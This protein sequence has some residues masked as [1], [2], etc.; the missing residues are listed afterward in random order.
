MISD[1]LKIY[2]FFLIIRLKIFFLFVWKKNN[3]QMISDTLKIYNFFFFFNKISFE[4]F[5][6]RLKKN[7]A[8]YFWYPED[9]IQ[10]L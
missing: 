10:L 2:I 4:F 8:N 9:N 3:M 6:I 7:H 1:T 5:F